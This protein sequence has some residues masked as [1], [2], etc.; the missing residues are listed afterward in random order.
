MSTLVIH[1]KDSTTTFL[2]P[3]YAPIPNKTIINGGV[4][5][6]ELE[7]LIDEHNRIIMLG[8]GSPQ[9]LLFVNQFPNVGEYIIDDSMVE[10]ISAKTNNIFIWC[11]SDQFVRS[12]R[13]NGFCTGMFISEI[14]EAWY[15]DFYDVDWD[16]INESNERFSSIVSKYVNGRL[17]VLFKNVIHEYG[18]LAQ[19]NPIARFNLERLNFNEIKTDSMVKS[20]PFPG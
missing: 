5:K 20:N 8:H 17:D 9:G 12:N 11:H 14:E 19:S 2:K 18:L 6:T 7:Q 10:S 4:N 3:I 15:N 13:L 16:M 1:P